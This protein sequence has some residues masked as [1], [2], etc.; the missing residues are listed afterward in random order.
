M[1]ISALGRTWSKTLSNSSW[2]A[3]SNTILVVL[4]FISAN[5]NFNSHE[6]LVVTPPH[7]NKAVVVEWDTADKE[8]L[9]GF[10]LF[11]VT[12]IGNIT[13]KNVTMVAD[14][15]SSYLDAPIYSQVRSEILSLADDP[16]FQKAS[17]INY[18][19]PERT[20]YE[21]DADKVQKVFVV[22]QLITSGFDAN[23]GR[24]SAGVET[25]WVTYEMALAMR[26]GKPVI[27][28]FTSYKGNQ[29]HTMKW[30]A[31]QQKPAQ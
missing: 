27:T 21:L 29:P 12:L 1:K 25:K 2:M 6:R 23:L 10:G 18:F 8:Y 31:S 15:V 28:A 9:E 5:K 24:N 4:L 14:V 11:T 7:L 13:P 26:A 19:A 17:A 20:V 3:I 22:G 16:V 30:L